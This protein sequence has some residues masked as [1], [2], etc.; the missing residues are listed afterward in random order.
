VIREG[1][2]GGAKTCRDWE[3]FRRGKEREMEADV[4]QPGF[5]QPQVVMVS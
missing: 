3:C 4:N 5:N 2:G 1:K